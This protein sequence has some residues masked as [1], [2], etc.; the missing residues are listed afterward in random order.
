MADNSDAEA[1]LS[2]YIPSPDLVRTLEP[3]DNAGG[4]S[5]SKLWRVSAV[6]NA[7]RGVPG[8]P[9]DLCLRRW[10]K[11]HPTRERL[12]FIHAT[13]DRA[14]SSGLDFVPAPLRTTD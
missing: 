10:P 13:L 2:Y 3:L 7:L 12:Q 11:E 8:A 4:W 6:G 14:C 1:V 9:N 5:G